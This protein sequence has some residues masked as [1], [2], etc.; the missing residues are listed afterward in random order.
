MASIWDNIKFRYL[1]GNIATK[2]I[3]INVGIFLLIKLFVVFC[4]LFQFDGSRF[5]LLLQLP[6]SWDQIL[7][8]PW[9]LL[10]YMFVH[11]GF[12]HLLFN[13]IW[14]Y[15]FGLYFLRWFSSRQ[16]LMVY[17]LGGLTGGLFYI[18]AYNL[19][20]LYSSSVEYTVLMGASASVLAL[21][22]SVAFYRPNESLVFM[23]I[24][25]VKLKWLAV[26]MVI[27]DLLSLAGDNAGGS[28]AHLGGALFGL[29]FGFF[30]RENLSLS[31]FGS[32]TGGS[33]GFRAKT[34]KRTKYHRPRFEKANR[35]RPESDQEYRDRKKNEEDYRDA[36]LDKIKQSG[37][38]S[39]SK[40]EKQF[41]FKSGQ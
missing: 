35:A 19:F 8:R 15:V 39:L 2:L 27:I 41:L 20:P 9:T 12:F 6:A 40:K 34:G 14:L 24:G 13:M 22:L 23:F 33:R 32:K 5:I 4:H 37:Y 16:L 29:L 18:I 36:I 11:L 21:T 10:T 25:Q 26:A 1:Q 7:L 3:F 17:L 31:I 38:E 28:L 30:S